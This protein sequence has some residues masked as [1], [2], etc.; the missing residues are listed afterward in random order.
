L[1]ANMAVSS[2]AI[3]PTNANVLYAGTGEGYFNFDGI[4]GAGIFKSTDGGTTWTQL[5]ATA[6]PGSGDFLFVNDLPVSANN[7]NGGDA[8]TGTGLWRSSNAGTSWSRQIDAASANGCMDIALRPGLSPDTAI[9]SC[10]TFSATDASSGIW[11]S[12]AANGASP[13][14][15]HRLGPPGSG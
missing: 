12:A 7:P 3:D 1:M 2:L 15:S 14:W 13:G 9:V 8:A 11:R 4:A 10:G 5:A 6:P